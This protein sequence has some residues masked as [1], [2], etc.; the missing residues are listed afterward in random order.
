MTLPTVFQTLPIKQ[1]LIF[2]NT[3]Q[4]LQNISA[5]TIQKYVH[6]ISGVG[7]LR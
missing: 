2:I 3:F 5:S 7:G 1:G 6:N 4:C